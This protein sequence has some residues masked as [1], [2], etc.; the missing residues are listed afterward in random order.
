MLMYG[1]I[2][3]C[4]FTRS[5]PHSQQTRNINWWILQGSSQRHLGGYSLLVTH[6]RFTKSLLESFPVLPTLRKSV[7]GQFDQIGYCTRMAN[8]VPIAAAGTSF[9][10]WCFS[11][12]SFMSRHS[13]KVCVVNRTSLL[14][15]LPSDPPW[16]WVFWNL[17]GLVGYDFGALTLCGWASENTFCI[18]PC[19]S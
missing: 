14:D 15:S 2:V 9:C 4:L 5:L 1:I 3:T 8:E 10:S 18:R 17:P 6:N 12:V 11:M 16:V 19:S 7:L 13:C